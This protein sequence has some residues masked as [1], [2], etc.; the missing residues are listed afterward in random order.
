MGGGHGLPKG[1]RGNLDLAV[2]FQLD[3]ADDRELFIKQFI[4]KKN[5]IIGQFLYQKI[6]SEPYQAIILGVCS[7]EMDFKEYVFRYVAREKVPKFF[8]GRDVISMIPSRTEQRFLMKF[9][10]TSDLH[11]LE[12]GK[13]PGKLNLNIR[14]S[15]L[16]EEDLF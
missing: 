9:K 5:K 11:Y 12:E 14:S 6:V 4:S 13:G 2:A 8:I 7:T 10:R 16:V 3:N 1:V 15:P